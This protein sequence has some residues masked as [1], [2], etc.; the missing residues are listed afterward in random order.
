MGTPGQ[1][2]SLTPE[3]VAALHKQFS[4]AR[5]NINNHLALIVAASELLARKPDSA[6]RVAAAL[7]DPPDRIVE[8]L[9]RF[10]SNFE[11]ALQIGRADL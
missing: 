3:E 5:H 1:A 6:A 7:K 10:S 9:R 4:D 11:Q 2:I 8:E